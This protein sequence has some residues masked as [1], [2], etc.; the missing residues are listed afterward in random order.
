[1]NK[2]LNLSFARKI[3]VIALLSFFV[4]FCFLGNAGQTITTDEPWHYQYGIHLLNGDSTRPGFDDSKMPS[5]AL[6][7]I[8]KKVAS[9]LPDG[10]IK[11]IL[12]EMHIARLMTILFSALVG[13]LVFHWS[14]S[15][16]GFIPGLLSLILYIFDPNIISNSQL[17]TT[18]IYATGTITFACY[19]LWRFAHQRNWRNGLLCAFSM[20]LS[21]IAKYTGVALFPL[22]FLILFLYDL[23]AF[24][25]AYQVNAT[26]TIKTYFLRFACYTFISLFTSI[27][28]I[29]FAF[30]FN[31]TFTR[32]GAY[33]FRSKLF[34]TLQTD[35][36]LLRKIPVPTAY[37]YLLGLDRVI[38][39]SKGVFDV[40][41]L[42]NIRH[43]VGFP[44]YYLVSSLLKEPIATQI[45]ILAALVV[46][47]VNKQRFQHFLL[48]EL[49]LLAP[50]IFFAIYF[51]FFYNVQLGIRFYLV[52]FPLTFIFA[53]NLFTAWAQFSAVQKGT[54][55]ALCVYLVVSVFSYYPYYASYFNE[56]IW[57]KTQTYK[58][59]AI[60]DIDLGQSK[61]ELQQY[62]DTHPDTVIAPGSIQPGKF[63]VSVNNLVGT[64]APP[65]KYAWLRNN[66]EPVGTIAYCYLIYDISAEDVAKV[67][68]IE[69][70]DKGK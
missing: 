57:D 50:V 67:C 23:P 52:L 34:Q 61:N 2:D 32:F 28:I 59:L 44:G 54:A 13:L 58:Y 4:V 3:I 70:C 35:V 56:L 69:K 68:A 26:G 22:F 60:S 7:A 10:S 63:V 46:Y 62:L 29:N 16:Y 27:L 47:F 36:P 37:P 39:R 49:F 20:G 31:H 30:L 15:L 1:M 66:F 55:I 24:I 12:N 21:Q 11:D 33:Q 8:P 53:G 18:D 25:E 64:I 51:N 9:Y 65:K 48:N 40:Y 38:Q 5:T 19:C 14:R 42:G 43:G 41:L 6:N 45:F 17:I